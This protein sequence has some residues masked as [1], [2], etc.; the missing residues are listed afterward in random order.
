M[1]ENHKHRTGL[2]RCILFFMLAMFVT[3]GV[4]SAMPKVQVHAASKKNTK[5]R[6]K[7]SK[8]TGKKTGSKV[9]RLANQSG[10]YLIY[11]GHNWWL[12]D[13]NGEKITGM[14]YIKMP[15][16]KK[17]KSGYYMFDDRGC[18]CRKKE[19]HRVDTVI[20]GKKFKGTYYFGGDNGRLYN[21][22]GWKT[23]N[24]KRYLLNS[25]GKRY[26]NRWKSGYYF[27]SNGTIA[28]NK[29]I[30]DGVYVDCDGRKCTEADMKINSL[31]K[32]LRKMLNGYYGSWSVYVKDLKTGGVVNLNES[33]MYSASVIK[34]FVMAS[35]FDQIKKGNLKYNSTVKG[36]LNEMITES[37]NEAYNQLVKYNS[38]S[39]IFLGG[40][41][42]INKYL[43]KNKYT[44]TGCH[45]TLHPASSASVGD[46][47]SNITSA[48]DCGILLEHIYNGTCVSSKYSKEMRKLLLAQT[49]RWKIPSGI[50]S[51]IKVANKTG[52]TSSVEHD[53]AIVY[54]KKKDYI[55][56]VFSNT[57][58]EDYALPRIRNISRTVYNYLN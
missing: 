39:R 23:I 33:A 24:G 29:K 26:E 57:G 6:Q 28:K 44:K 35:T 4:S 3:A 30:S 11:T 20:Y 16:K 54:G 10:E 25:D 52:E 51:G 32:K 22:A 5:S 15:T 21:K 38:K 43:K 42:V 36:L 48:K 9:V 27:K 7:S 19:F 41:S 47:Q 8:K 55:I 58:S 53:M 31:K 18:L 14:Q 1:K 40:A 50:P 17:L 12:K 49:R 37:D 56:C 45:H 34:P 2:Y 46:G 13:K